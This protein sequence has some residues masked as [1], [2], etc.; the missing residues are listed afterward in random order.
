MN[1]E[2]GSKHEAA[3]L[4]GI[5]TRTLTRYRS[6]YKWVEGV[7]FF[8]LNPTTVRY[9]LTL[10]EHWR[11]YKDSPHVHQKACDNFVRSLPTSKSK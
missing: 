5:S 7:H 1:I 6:Q 2:I 10:L 9:N 4:L 11:S 3:S 8:K